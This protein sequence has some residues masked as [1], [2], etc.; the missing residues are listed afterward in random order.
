MNNHVRELAWNG[1]SFQ[2][3]DVTSDAGCTDRL[4]APGSHLAAASISGDSILPEVY[5]IDVNNHVRE[6]AWNG[7]SFQTTDVTSDAGCTASELPA[8]GSP[9]AATGISGSGSPEVYFTDAD[10]HVRTLAWNGSNWQTSDVTAAAGCTTSGLPAPGS[11]L[12]AIGITPGSPPEVYFTDA[13]KH[14][15][16]LAW[17]ESTSNWQFSDVT[18]ATD[19]PPALAAGSPLA[20]WSISAGI[21]PEVYFTDTNNHVCQLAWNGS[22]W[23]FSDVT[24]AA[25]APPALAAGSPLAAF[26]IAAGILPEVYYTDTNNHVCQ[27]AWNGS[28]W[29][30]S[31][32]TSAAG[33]TASELPAPGSPLAAWSISAGWFPEVYFTDADNHVWELAFTGNGAQN[34][35]GN[36]NS[37]KYLSQ[38]SIPGTHDTLTFGCDVWA[39]E[40]Q[41]QD[42]NFD[43]TAQLNAG[44]RF[45]DLRLRGVLT[46]DSYALFGYH[47]VDILLVE[48]KKNVLDPTI[49]FLT[50]NPSECVIYLLTNCGVDWTVTKDPQHGPSWDWLLKHGLQGYDSSWYYTENVMPTLQQVRQKIVICDCS[51]HGQTIWGGLDL[52]GGPYNNWGTDGKGA[53]FTNTLRM[54]D[55]TPVAIYAQDIYDDM[56]TKTMGDETSAIQGNIAAAEADTDPSHWY[57]TGTNRASGGPSSKLFATGWTYFNPLYPAPFAGYNQIALEQINK[58][59]ATGHSDQRNIGVVTS[60]FPNDTPN[61]IGAIIARNPGF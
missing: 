11:P 19:A 41:D 12:A 31:D 15:C 9:L 48:F 43:I 1:Q 14:V 37:S 55:G 24:S 34:W 21:K 33:C 52:T 47:N 5:F 2:T 32:V 53:P 49:S 17:N 57:T 42:G 44:I 28:N 29:Q 61:Y 23:Q 50:D 7:Q 4:P 35:M 22:N 36:V 27:L 40:A 39:P 45:F 56:S 58:I 59:S 3:T 20:A 13:D 16:Q 8:P 54:Q 46:V 51:N 25:D 38:L 18:A 26:S 30:F 60:D 10:N 6:L